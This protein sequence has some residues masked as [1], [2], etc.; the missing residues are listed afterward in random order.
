MIEIIKQVI[1]LLSH[2]YSAF[3]VTTLIFLAF[4]MP[5]K[6]ITKNI[7][8]DIIVKSNIDKVAHFLAF[9]AW[10]FCWQFV[11]KNYLNTLLIGIAY[12]I[13][14]EVWQDKM[15][16]R[17]KRT[18]SWYDALADA[19]GVVAGLLAYYIVQLLISQYIP[20]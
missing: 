4:S 12:G 13:I 15:P 5:T 19:I 18:F 11:Y 1:A 7:K 3:F 2:K 9:A 16:G 14:I 6:G 10:A 17:F 20:V 8:S